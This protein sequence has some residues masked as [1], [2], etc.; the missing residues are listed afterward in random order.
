MQT[1]S[2]SDTSRGRI[3]HPTASERDRIGRSAAVLL[4]PAAQLSGAAA[5]TDL[6]QLAN[7]FAQAR[8]GADAAAARSEGAVVACRWLS[9]DGAAVSAASGTRLAVDGTITDGR[10]YDAVLVAAFDADDDA[11]LIE[12]LERLRPACAW[13]R[14]QHAAGALLAACGSGVFLLAETGLLDGR[15][16]TAPW[17]QQG[18]FHRRYP[19]V[20]LDA[21]QRLTESERLLCAGTLAGLFPL[22]LRVVAH[23]TSPN[24]AD[25][26][27]K[28]TLIDAGAAV[29][30]PQPQT[31][32]ARATHDPLVAAA[33]YYLQQHYADKAPLA[34]LARDLA[35]SP[36][37]LVR[38]FRRA[39]GTTPQGWLQGLRIEAAQRMLARTGLHVDRIGR[40]V[41][42]AD[43]GFFK[44]LFRQHT[45]MTPAAWRAA[46]EGEPPVRSN[47]S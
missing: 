21:P 40:Q 44:R 47:R 42:Y 19:A 10:H 23:L 39:L 34:G 18:L 38:R 16:A 4:P 14:E 46:A 20:R 26:L 12:R 36:R 15:V 6:L 33:Q 13:L 41:G 8:T 5:L 1:S 24:T 25:W 3:G 2:G 35:V 27:A 11:T 31:A 7:R 17:W 29:E 9:L 28:T 43:S 22:A 32:L 45:G 30:T 37:T